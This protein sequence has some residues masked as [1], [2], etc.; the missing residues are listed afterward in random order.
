MSDGRGTTPKCV[1][2]VS[3]SPDYSGAMWDGGG[4]RR[5]SP[6]TLSLSWRLLPL[7]RRV[8]GRGWLGYCKRC[9]RESP[10][11]H[12]IGKPRCI[13]HKSDEKEGSIEESERRGR[14]DPRAPHQQAEVNRAWVTQGGRE[15]GRKESAVG[16]WEYM[17]RYGELRHVIHVAYQAELNE[18]R[19]HVWRP[20]DGA[21]GSHV[22]ER[23][24]PHRKGGEVLGWFEL[25]C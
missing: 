5:C 2:V 19:S 8:C 13:G 21:V 23:R 11:E 25:P 15:R 18:L 1:G 10:T 22:P 16:K 24:Q 9:E 17:R 7:S 12:R 4:S 6:L 14:C 20:L 3:L